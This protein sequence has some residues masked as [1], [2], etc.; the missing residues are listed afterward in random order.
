MS[1]LFGKPLSVVN[2]GLA[3]FAEAVAQAGTPVAAVQ[4]APPGGDPAA[5]RALAQL[6]ADPRV[7]EA[8]A[9]AYAAYLAA[10]PVLEGIGIAREVLPGMGD[11]MLL[12][13]GPPIAFERMCGPMKG[14]VVGAILLEGW[15]SDHAAAE[16]LAASGA[17]TFDPCH[18]HDAVGPMAGVISPSMPVYIIRNTV[19]GNRTY[20]NF[21]EGLGKVLRMGANS[22]DVIERLRWMGKT[23]A[24][25]LKRAMEIT[26]PIELKPMIAQALH[27]G[28]EVHNR[29]IAASG[30]LFKRFAPAL[31]RSGVAAEDAAASLDFINGNVHTFINL[32]M[33]AC[34]AML[35]AAANVP[36]SSMV[37][38]MSRNGVE[39]GIRVS[40]TGKQWFTAPANMIKGLYFAGFSEADACPDMGDSAI[41]ETAGVGGFAMAAAPAIVQFVGGTPQQALE[42]TL[43]MQGITL[44]ANPA[45]SLPQLN[46]GGTPSGIDIRKVIDTGVLPI[47]NTGIAHKQAGIG[48]VGAG[49]TNAPMGCFTG[50]IVA[51]AAGLAKH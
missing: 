12:H 51:L 2:V 28:D 19:H 49:I 31:M 7:D 38:T 45:L 34:K 36:G 18:H 37:V 44:G 16:K 47:I 14:A 35:D 27:M 11:R 40:G 1:A 23:F 50:A 41:T 5:A 13:A 32:S 4:W 9:K 26:G 29:N 20:S 8:N 3:S 33:A 24:P 15:A 42:N 21:N 6:T 17:I 46:F 30:L 10:E 43:S 48:Q 39:F 25:T 22:P